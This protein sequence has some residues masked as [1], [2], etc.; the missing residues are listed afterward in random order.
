MNI[1][2]LTY[3]VEVAKT[4]SLAKA[5]EILNIS[6]SG[7][8]Q[9]ISRLESELN[10]KLF[11]RSRTGAVTTKEGDAIIEK[12]QDALYA[13]YQIKAEAKHQLNNINDL[14]R[15]SAIPGLAGPIIDTYILLKQKEST[16]KIEV[17]E[18]AS[19]EIIE[20]I[21]DDKTD[22]GFI[23][24]NKAS[25]DLVS[26]LHFIPVMNGKISVYT[27]IDS[28]LANTMERMTVDL[29][30]TQKFVLYK[31]E[32]VQNFINNF[33]RLYGPI[34]VFFKTT[35]LDVITKAVM[36]L[37]A[38]TIGHD[39]SAVFNHSFP[40]DTVKAIE[41]ADLSDTSFRF[42]WLKKHDNKLSNEA[43]HYIEEVNKML[44]RQQ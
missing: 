18:K 27:S 11:I 3:I 22:I 31:D 9:A 40:S 25:I 17:N 12:A 10:I 34:D 37:G 23:A 6:Q 29:L 39:I 20:D 44:W 19:M 30:K 33:Q 43:K 1:E 8:S 4:K 35:N 21:K 14:L 5:A 28:P 13:L 16:L 24:I 2:Q 42:G 7:L 26:D 36:E 32:Y 15:I 41:I 38:V